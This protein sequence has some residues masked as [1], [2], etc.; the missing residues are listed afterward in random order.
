M[1]S[2]PWQSSRVEVSSI[3]GIELSI[4]TFDKAR[5]SS[6]PSLSILYCSS[7]FAKV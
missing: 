5:G 1:F 6:S 3:K 4:V 7:I 2:N